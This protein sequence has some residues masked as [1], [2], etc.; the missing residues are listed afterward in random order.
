MTLANQS[1]A[2]QAVLRGQEYWRLKQVIQSPG[3]IFEIDQS[4]RALYIGPDSDISEV[5]ATYYNPDTPTGLETADI[6]PA[7]P[8]VG[9]FDSLLATTVPSTGQK[10]RLLVSPVAIV[11]NN[12]VRPPPSPFAIPQRSFNIPAQIDLIAALKELPDIPAVR[13]DKTF[14]FPSVPFETV[15]AGFTDGSTD[16]IIPIY[17][18]RLISVQIVAPS[19]TGYDMSFYFAALQPGI[20][21]APNFLGNLQL[22]P[23][24][25]PSTK[26]AVLKASDSINFFN[27]N[28]FSAPPGPALIETFSFD[29]EP[30]I[31]RG[32][33]GEADLL[34][35]NLLNLPIGVPVP[36][37][38][39]VDVFI[40]VSDREV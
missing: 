13:A 26:A 38:K 34:I 40:K 8:F 12:Y 11:S 17:G 9:R 19:G 21:T 1:D 2:V 5:R 37:T 27:G 31:A 36:G 6:S 35:I 20:N 15:G 14:R 32:P 39:F 7:G 24:S 30:S 4:T 16:L 18:R 33:K 28:T 29:A 3:D 22:F 10:A 25:N 23:L